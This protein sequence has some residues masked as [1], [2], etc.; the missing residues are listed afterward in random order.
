MV[1]ISSSGEPLTGSIH[2]KEYYQEHG[3]MSKNG[4]TKS[5]TKLVRD[6]SLIEGACSRKYG[7]NTRLV[8]KVNG[9][10]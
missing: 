6:I 7:T 1:T 9:N 4:K 3:M 5:G 2:S 10:K 8:I